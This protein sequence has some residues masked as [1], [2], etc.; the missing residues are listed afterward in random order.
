VGVV[1]GQTLVVGDIQGC[2]DELEELLAAVG[3]I[4][5]RDQ[6]VAVGDLVNRG[7]RS[8]AVLRLIRQLAGEVILGNHELYLLGVVAG[9]RRYDDTLD[10]V[11]VAEDLEELL[12]WLVDRPEPLVLT[13]EWVA[14]HAGFP[15]AFRLAE[16]A[17][18]VNAAVRD[19]WR[20]GGSLA[21]RAGRITASPS[22]RFLTTVRYCD[23][24]GRTPPEPDAFDPPGFLPW[25]DHW[26]PGPIVAFGHWA[27]LDPARAQRADLRFLDTGCVYGRALT[28]WLVEEDRL[29]SVPA[30]RVY[31]PPA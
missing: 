24:A 1:A 23:A 19:A 11:L 14:V 13:R 15:P 4:P 10:E 7:P 27:R 18:M 28:G 21:E 20:R 26:H 22:A 2:C 5:G 8:L 3:F 9:K 17:A 12:D 31:W 16:D 6:L 29:V 25:F 30:Q